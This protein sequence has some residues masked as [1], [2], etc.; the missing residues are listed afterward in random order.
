MIA[1]NQTVCRHCHAGRVSRPGGLCWHCYH[2][3]GVAVLYVQR[4]P[5]IEGDRTGVQP[6]PDAPTRAIP[7]SPAKID[8]LQARASAGQQLWHPLDAQIELE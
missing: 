2:T 6:L 4:R 3:E 1:I 5:R 7:G 8:V